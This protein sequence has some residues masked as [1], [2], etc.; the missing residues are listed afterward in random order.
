MTTRMTKALMVAV[1]AAIAICLA[2]LP[3]AHAAKQVDAARQIQVLRGEADALI[4]EREFARASDK[5]EGL[6][7]LLMKERQYPEAL[8]VSFEIE[9]VAG[10]ASERR[11]PWHYV[12]IG[13]VYLAMGHKDRF[14]EWVERAIRERSFS[15]QEYFRGAQLDPVRDDPRFQALLDACAAVIGVGRE[16]R[17]FEVRLLDGSPFRLSAQRGKVVLV[18][19]W[20]VRCGPCRKEMPNLKAIYEEFKDR[21]L[22]ILG[23]SLDTEKPLLDDYLLQAALPWKITCSWD[24]WSDRTAKLYQISA[25]PST[26]L[27]DRRGVVRYCDVRGEELRKAVQVL[28]TEAGIRS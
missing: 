26:W 23:I 28:I 20:D 1:P 3:P 19:F 25:T 10:K 9:E 6:Q 15:R 22:E 5:L 24:G 27:I 11:S 13:E 17:D 8:K 18:D 7:M 21:G 4:K 14:F 2:A 16:A 12:R